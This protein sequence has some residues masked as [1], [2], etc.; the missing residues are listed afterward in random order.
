MKEQSDGQE[1]IS[2][3]DPM[4]RMPAT[5]RLHTKIGDA[6]QRLR[7]EG[8]KSLIKATGI[9]HT[10]SAEELS[11]IEAQYNH[12]VSAQEVPI[13]LRGSDSATI[14][15]ISEN[16]DEGWRSIF[17]RLTKDGSP[18]IP[19]EFED[20]VKDWDFPYFSVYTAD[21]HPPIIA[22]KDMVDTDEPDSTGISGTV[23]GYLERL[24]ESGDQTHALSESEAQ[25]LIDVLPTLGIDAVENAALNPH[26]T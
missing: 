17:L 19:P 2:N 26:I 5:M 3:F 24:Y 15:F 25:A 22:A 23:R 7:Q 21:E 16:P 4:E 9:E 10:H 8:L 1:G 20:Q 13:S 11:T 12:P 18:Y 14:E 6:Y